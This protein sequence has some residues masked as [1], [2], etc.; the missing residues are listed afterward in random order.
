MEHPVATGL[1]E[2]MAAKIEFEVTPKMAEICSLGEKPRVSALGLSILVHLVGLALI[3]LVRFPAHPKV[4]LPQVEAVQVIPTRTHVKFAPSGGS[5]LARGGQRGGHALRFSLKQPKFAPAL[6]A[7]EALQQEAKRETAIMV[8]SY[9]FHEMYGF[10]PG[11][12]YKL[13]VH[14]S[15][16]LP[17][18]SPE[19]LPPHFEQ[20]VV[21]DI[22]IDKEGK[23]ADAQIVT[24]FVDPAIQ[25]I[26]LAAVR[27]FRYTP[28]TRD[29]L[30]IPSQ[31]EIVIAIPS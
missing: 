14:S 16:E 12:Q 27:E 10:Y 22:T 31:L 26:L 17:H 3:L 20:I 13:P 2:A 18:I 15:G 23:V 5:L 19:Q 30:P 29:D 9:K 7:G 11:H 28:A 4:I 25:Q 6:S 8:Q 21:V 1:K 24:G